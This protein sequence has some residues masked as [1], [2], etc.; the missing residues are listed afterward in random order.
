MEQREEILKVSSLSKNFPGIKA[1]KSVSFSLIKG[2]THALVGANGA[3]KSTLIKIL[4][5][6]QLADEGEIY[7]NGKKKVFRTPID[8][9]K[10]RIITVPQ[11]I[12]VARELS[13]TANIFL[14][15][16]KRFARGIYLD[17]NKM[18]KQ[19][20]KYLDEI[21]VDLD[22]TMTLENLSVG[23]MQMVMIANALSKNAQILIL[24]EP[25]SALSQNE[26]EHLFK[27]IEELNKKG[28]SII[29]ISHHFDEIFRIANRA[30]V[31]KNGE[32]MGTYVINETSKEELI[33]AMIGRKLEKDIIE[34]KNKELGKNLLEVTDLKTSDNRVRGVSFTLKQKQILGLY[35]IVG[36]G[37]TDVAKAIFTGKG[38]SDGQIRIKDKIVKIKSPTQ[39]IENG[40]IYASESR[41]EEGLLVDL[42]IKRNI[43]MTVLK[44]I[45][46]CSIINS[47][48]EI[49]LADKYMKVLDILAPSINFD[50]VN[51]SGGNQQKV[52]ISRL[53]ATDCDV[54]IFDEPTVGIDVGVKQEILKLISDIAEM[55]K[56]IIIISSEIE[57]IMKVCDSISVM[58]FGKIEKTF[59]R[60]EFR[61]NEI[62]LVATGGDKNV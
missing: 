25:T 2:E 55:G 36:A 13:I 39:A 29:Y 61:K 16:E 3:G 44:S 12:D 58:R 30:T 59:S 32:C 4:A 14:G 11:E 10:N 26:A 40:I 6:F 57:E 33:T 17:K 54:L 20:R 8:S 51:L 22:E 53:L 49:K 24:D 15:D 7:L 37:R 28:V 31:L 48:K 1:L 5:G 56:G 62:M 34:K 35:G 19:A 46:K 27:Q 52:V 60:D 23:S 45:S 18:N 9:I 21:G 41:K 38:I 50:V 42:S 47:K 43:S